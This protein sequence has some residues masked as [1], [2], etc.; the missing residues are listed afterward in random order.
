MAPCTA[1][2][3]LSG[4]ETVDDDLLGRLSFDDLGLS[5]WSDMIE[6]TTL[7]LLLL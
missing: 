5:E 4:H 2:A 6:E 1:G 7:L 3:S